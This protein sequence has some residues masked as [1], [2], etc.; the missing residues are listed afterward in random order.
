MLKLHDYSDSGNGYKIRLLLTHLGRPFELHHV[1]IL[2]GESR[3]AEFLARNPNGKI[4]V[5]QLEDGS[6]LSESN[7]ILFYLAEGTDYLP[8]SALGRARVLQWLFFEQYSHEPNIATRRFMLKHMDPESLA[9]ELL[10]EKLERGYQALGVMN[11]HLEQADF[12]VNEG[13][14]IADIGLFAYTHVADE[15]GF[16]LSRFPQVQAWCA[17]VKR[18]PGFRGLYAEW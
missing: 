15:G 16:D 3:T 10:A 13:Y 7:A 1:D 18:Q 17:R 6:S 5:L 2:K 9:E 11:Q 14:S 8:A 12:F 4:P